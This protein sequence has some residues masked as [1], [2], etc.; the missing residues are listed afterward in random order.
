MGQQSGGRTALINAMLSMRA[1]VLRSNRRRD[2]KWDHGFTL[3]ELLVVVAVIAILAGI[4]LPTLGKSKQRAQAIYCL[5]NTHE[6]TLAW[7]L[8]ADDNNGRLAYNLGANATNAIGMASGWS[9]PPMRLNW[10]NNV[11]SWG[12]DADNTNAEKMVETGLGPYLLAASVYR[13]PSD[14]VVSRDQLNVGWHAR[15]RSYSMNAMIGDAGGFSRS[16]SNINNPEYIQFFTMSAIPQPADIFVFLDEHPDSI[17]DGYFVNRAYRL[18][19]HDLPASF[20]NN[21]AE[22]SFADG[23]ADMHRWRSP[24]T[25]P[26]PYPDA[27]GLPKKLPT[28]PANAV[29]ELADFY[30]V[31]SHMSVEQSKSGDEYP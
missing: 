17:D 1:T 13:C 19:W 21:G 11:L 28:S 14:H 23:H 2:V 15:V 5:N 7:I 4:L 12:L 24:T 10:V 8:Y 27:A 18:E 16:G 3:I 31:I 26:P 22:F 20:H 25:T 6:L 29:A 30:W 9:S